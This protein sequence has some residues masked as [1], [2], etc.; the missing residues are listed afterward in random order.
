M[1]ARSDDVIEQLGEDCARDAACRLYLG[2]NAPAQPTGLDSV[3]RE[4]RSLVRPVL[5][6]AGWLGGI[7]Y[8][9]K[10]VCL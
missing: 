10:L 3:A 2:I 9:G 6:I 7:L 8:L 1:G 4:L 5:M